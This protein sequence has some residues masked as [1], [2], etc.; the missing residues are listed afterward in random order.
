MT[1]V[2]MNHTVNLLAAKQI[3]K[4]KKKVHRAVIL[5]LFITGSKVLQKTENTDGGALKTN[6]KN[7][8]NLS[9]IKTGTTVL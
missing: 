4:L 2:R 6:H 7:P 8:L 1:A 3:S 5:C 9:T